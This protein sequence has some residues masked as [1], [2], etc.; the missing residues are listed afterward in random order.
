VDYLRPDSSL[1]TIRA[2]RSVILSAGAV[3]SP[4]LLMVSGIGPA[5]TLQRHGIEVRHDLPAVGQNLQDHVGVYLNYRVDQPTYNSEQTALRQARHA[6]QWFLFGRGPGTTP[7]ALSMAFVRSGPDVSEPDLQ[8]H[9]TPVG[10]R[11][12]PEALI[13]LDEPVVTAIPNVNRPLSRGE[14][15]IAGS[16]IRSAPVIKPRLLDHPRDLEV[17]R[18]G[19]RMLR[20]IFATPPLAKHVVAELAPGPDVAADDQWEDYLRS[21]SVTIFHPCG[22]CKMGVDA[23]AVVDPGLRLRGLESLHVIDAS[24]M[25]HLVSGNINAPVMMIGERGADLV[26]EQYP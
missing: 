20:V 12:T 16:D 14:L 15:T 18:R 11:L 22:T 23:Q 17:L 4:H 7:G 5:A 21:D 1:V 25:P 3:A 9:F 2:N 8:L 26:L 10:Y 13:V 24:I 6:L 19:C